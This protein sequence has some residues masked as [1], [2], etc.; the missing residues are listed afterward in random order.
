MSMAQESECTIFKKKSYEG[1]PI[2][3][4]VKAYFFFHPVEFNVTTWN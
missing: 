3:K 1:F 2:D 4:T